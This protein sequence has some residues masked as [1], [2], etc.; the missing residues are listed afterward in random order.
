MIQ[1]LSPSHRAPYKN[2]PDIYAPYFAGPEIEV[3]YFSKENYQM[4]WSIGTLDFLE[5]CC[6]KAVVKP[7]GNEKPEIQNTFGCPL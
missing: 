7:V 6:C 2:R 1:F 3:S 4:N 5:A